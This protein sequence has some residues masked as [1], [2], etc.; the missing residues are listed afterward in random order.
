MAW[1]YCICICFGTPQNPDD[2]RWK[3]C[4]WESALSSLLVGGDRR[5]LQFWL[6]R[7]EWSLG[8]QCCRPSD[9]TL[10]QFW[11][12][13]EGV[14]LFVHVG[15]SCRVWFPGFCY[16]WLYW[17]GV[18]MYGVVHI[19]AEC[20]WLLMISGPLQTPCFVLTL[21]LVQ[22]F[23][24]TPLEVKQCGPSTKIEWHK[25][26]FKLTTSIVLNPVRTRFFK[27]SHPMPP[28]PTTRTLLFAIL[29]ARFPCR[30]PF[31]A[32][33][34][35][36]YRSCNGLKDRLCVDWSFKYVMHSCDLFIG[37]KILLKST[38]I[39]KAETSVKALIFKCAEQLLF[40]AK[41][42]DRVFGGEKHK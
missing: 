1:N 13:E 32:A 11:Y 12:D 10:Q 8:L 26:G 35:I 3:W 9:S 33:A 36:A 22:W 39:L 31:K 37:F 27:S 17:F 6:W 18:G 15:L 23:S 34:I 20:V 38:I 7:Q 2:W 30:T 29:S 41:K 25:W 42:W 14:S 4:W 21:D 16:S 5:F 24:W 40:C 19:T 28:A